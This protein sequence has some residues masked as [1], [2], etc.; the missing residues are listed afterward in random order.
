[1]PF[2]AERKPFYHLLYVQVIIAITIGVAAGLLFQD[3]ATTPGVTRYWTGGTPDWRQ[4]AG[5]MSSS[6]RS[7][8]PC[9]R[10]T[11]RCWLSSFKLKMPILGPV[12]R[13]ASTSRFARTLGTL[14]GSGVPVLQA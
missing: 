10:L 9:C 13:K 11:S 7:R 6:W 1:M 14:L 4:A 2:P 5:S 12:F 8:P 3:F